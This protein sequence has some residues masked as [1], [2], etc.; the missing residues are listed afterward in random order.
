[1]AIEQLM[2]LNGT[3]YYSEIA[4]ACQDDVSNS[5]TDMIAGV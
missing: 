4:N 1:M 2:P 3:I 5:H